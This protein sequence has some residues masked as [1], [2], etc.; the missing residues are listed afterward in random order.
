MTVARSLTRSTAGST[1]IAAATLRW[2]LR[3][4]CITGYLNPSHGRLPTSTDVKLARNAV[5][6]RMLTAS[7]SEPDPGRPR[8]GSAAD[9]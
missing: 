7:V 4:P 3:G 6:M 1:A 9:R 2:P 8:P 5:P